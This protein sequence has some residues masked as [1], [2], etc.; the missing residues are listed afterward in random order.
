MYFSDDGQDIR[1]AKIAKK[2]LFISNYNPSPYS[3]WLICH[4]FITFAV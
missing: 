2:D 3:K 4:N 1:R